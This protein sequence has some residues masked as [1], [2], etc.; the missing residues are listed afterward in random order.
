VPPLAERLLLRRASAR[1]ALVAGGGV[2]TYREL[3]ARAE[4]RAAEMAAAP[5][6]E[7]LP[8]AND[9]PSVIELLASLLAG[10]PRRLERPAPGGN[11]GLRP[12]TPLGSRTPDPARLS[13]L[14]FPADPGKGGAEG[15]TG[16]LE[17]PRPSSG[18]AGAKPPIPVSG[19]AVIQATSGTT[20]RPKVVA[21]THD[22]LADELEACRGVFGYRE[23]DL[24]FCPAP[25]FHAYGLVD[26]LL[27][28][29]DAGAALL[30]AECAFTRRGFERLAAHPV[31][32]LV[33]SPPFL[34]HLVR[35]AAEHGNPF[36]GLR[37]ATSAGAPPGDDLVRAFRDAFGFALTNVYGMTELGTALV[38]APGVDPL[39]GMAGRPLPGY[40][41]K[42]FDIEGN[43]VLGVRKP[44][45]DFSGL[46][47]EVRSSSVRDGFFLTGDTGRLEGG[48]VYLAGRASE[49]INV[50]GEKVNPADVEACARAV[51]G[52]LD[53]CAFAMPSPT[54]GERVALYVQ[55]A[56]DGPPDDV[57]LETPL[58]AALSAAFAATLPAH[59]RPSKLVVSPDPVPRTATGKTLRGVLMEKYL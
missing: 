17:G 45:E 38:S 4:A 34:R 1:P 41:A 40:E 15:D 56:G 30:L 13:A 32:V 24:V 10:I 20:G 21:R 14:P 16:G 52:V 23:E 3:H 42:I 8:L 51:P 12:C 27:C 58:S 44:G 50:G 18:G 46:P 39:G 5:P 28:A 53:A 43:A 22:S 25:F 11:A 9:V 57:T 37:M 19:T 49:F 47:A 31:S 33:A 59:A 26:G 54:W 48:V 36:P 55:A 7:S 29:L 6:P 2:L 35:H